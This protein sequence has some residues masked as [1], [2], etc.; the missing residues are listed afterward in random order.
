VAD[1]GGDKAFD[2]EPCAPAPPSGIKIEL[3]EE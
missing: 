3:A 1:A 2:D